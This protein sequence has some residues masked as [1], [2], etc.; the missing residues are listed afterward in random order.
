MA[1]RK[2]LTP[3]EKQILR[4]MVAELYYERDMPQSEIMRE[5]KRSHNVHVSVMQVSRLL[6]E[7][8]EQKLVRFVYNPPLIRR[9]E[10]RLLSTFA[11]L[12]EA[13][14]IATGADFEFQLKMLGHRA[15]AY[16]EHFVKLKPRSRIGI[17]GGNTIYAMV[18]ALQQ[19]ERD[20]IAYPTAL[21]GRGPML[22]EHIDPMVLLSFLRERCGGQIPV[23]CTTVLPF[24]KGASPEAIREYND[25]LKR[26]HEKVRLVWEG[27]QEVDA[28]FASVGEVNPPDIYVRKL[29]RTLV[30]LLAD[31]NISKD[32]LQ[33][34][35]AVGDMS[36][37]LFDKQGKTKHPDW[38]FFITLGVDFFRNMASHYPAKRVV[39]IAG[40][41]KVES[42]RAALAGSLANVLI[43]DS[44]TAE[45]LLK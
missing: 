38:D 4:M 18:D 27:M 22:P 33:V 40:R 32:S 29:G 2:N 3:Q 42:L 9:L 35:G 14:V 37:S 45:A 17:S 34:A 11:C 30:N 6:K 13:I 19:R 8:K 36:Y 24:E 20:L 7:A 44:A 10:L 15:A 43:T 21:I 5:L 41:H 39:L 25:K 1:E 12:K 23:C 31:L 26:K 16:F 28:V